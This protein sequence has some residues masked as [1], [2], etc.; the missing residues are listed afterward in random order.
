MDSV[1][2]PTSSESYIALR[3]ALI[4]VQGDPSAVQ[5]ML[6]AVS[7]GGTSWVRGAYC[8]LRRGLAQGRLAGAETL[9][10]LIGMILEA[11]DPDTGDELSESRL[12]REAIRVLNEGIGAVLGQDNLTAIAHLQQLAEAVYSNESLRWVAW[13][14]IAMAAADEGNLDQAVIA[15]QEAMTL[16][17]KLDQ[18]ASGNS[19]CRFSEIEFR[20]GEYDSALDHL[21]QATAT[22]E[23]IGDRRGM[24]MASLA[25]A[26]ILATLK[27]KEQSLEAAR[28]AN[29]ADPD[30]EEPV[31]FLS[32]RALVGGELARASTMLEPFLDSGPHSPEVDRQRRLIE[33][34]RSEALPLP[35]VVD[36]LGLREQPVSTETVEALEVL[37]HEHPKFL[38]LRE[39]LAWSLVKVG[40]EDDASKHFKE[41]AALKLDPEIQSSV[42]LGLGCL[43]NRQ[44]RHRQPG[45]RVRAAASAFSQPSPGESEFGEPGRTREAMSVQE[46]LDASFEFVPGV[47]SEAVKFDADAV[48]A[49]AMEQ[50][51]AIQIEAEAPRRGEPGQ[52]PISA[53]DRRQP[54]GDHKAAASE[55][56]A[57]KAVFT[58]DLQLF[59]VP[60]L[61]DFLNSSRRTGTLVITSEHGIGAVHLKL[62]FIAGAASPSS[63][64]M[65]DLLIEKGVVTGEQLEQAVQHQKTD[66]PDRL[67]GA[68]L[69]EMSLVERSDLQ[70]ALEQQVRG[71]LKEMVDWTSGRFAFEPDRA[72][73]E[74]SSEIEIHLDTRGVLLDVLREYDEENR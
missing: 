53:A 48:A 42:F 40:R 10:N 72:G 73:P 12:H 27:R 22:F 18:Q 13:Y 57:P 36:F 71:A 31:V 2:D 60:D 61:L 67:L 54:T 11:Q 21:S 50:L 45:A 16:A 3:N 6:S 44:F 68:I 74:D 37:W 14:W 24:A 58:G 52:P 62:G 46:A 63:A 47:G 51:S 23:E 69:L 29:V 5:S 34:V 7:D 59:A 55:A 30:W 26:R 19:L 65:G 17:E 66:S 4:A 32:Q 64:N 49:G 41:M 70:Q 33:A 15:V 43:A 35:V 28:R 20:R 8:E 9:G 39:L 56:A 1:R 25:L 38:Q